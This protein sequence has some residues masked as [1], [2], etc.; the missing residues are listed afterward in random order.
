VV[1]QRFE[2]FSEREQPQ[3]RLA[4]TVSLRR[5]VAMKNTRERA[6]AVVCHEGGG[7]GNCLLRGAQE[8]GGDS[9]LRCGTR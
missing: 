6:K 8:G 5:K 4:L 2:S 9:R 7:G 3:R 1:A